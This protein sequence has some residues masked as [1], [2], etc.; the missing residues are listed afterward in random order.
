[1]KNVTFILYSGFEVG[2]KLLYITNIELSLCMRAP[3]H[4]NYDRKPIRE[5][6]NGQSI[7]NLRNLESKITKMSFNLKIKTSLPPTPYYSTEHLQI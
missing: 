5:D 4:L 3:E 6:L 7:T 2:R 1:M